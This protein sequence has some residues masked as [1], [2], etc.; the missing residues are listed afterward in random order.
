MELEDF[1][2]ELK[3]SL[4]NLVINEIEADPEDIAY[5]VTLI[6]ED[7]LT[8]L[9]HI[10]ERLDAIETRYEIVD[11]RLEGMLDRIDQLEPVIEGIE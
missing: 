4:S 1:I 2:K 10:A 8:I 5:F 9:Q 6:E 7:L 11:R 3:K